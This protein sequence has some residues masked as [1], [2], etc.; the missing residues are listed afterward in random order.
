MKSFYSHCSLISLLVFAMLSG[1][2]LDQLKAQTAYGMSLEEKSGYSESHAVVTADGKQLF[3]ARS[4]H[5]QN[6][7][8][9]D[10]SDIWYATMQEDG[11]WSAAINLGRPLN[12]H[13][14][15]YPV[16]LTNQGQ[17]LFVL[18]EGNDGNKKV[19]RSELHGRIWGNPVP[20]A[21]HHLDSIGLLIDF[22][23]SI[24]GV[25][26]IASI[27]D[28][29]GQV[30]LYYTYALTDNEWA[31]PTSLGS[32]VN[33]VFREL[34]PYLAA[35]GES[36]FFCRESDG[37]KAWFY[38]RKMPSDSVVQWQEPVELKTFLP[39]I[40]EASFINTSLDGRYAKL[41][42]I[43][44]RQ[45][46][47][48]FLTLDL[49]AAIRPSPV[50]VLSGSVYDADTGMPIE[51]MLDLAIVDDGQ[52][53]QRS[54]FGN[55][56]IVSKKEQVAQIVPRTEGYLPLS[57][58]LQRVDNIEKEEIDIDFP[59]LRGQAVSVNDSLLLDIA[60]CSRVVK[61]FGEERK[62]YPDLAVLKSKCSIDYLLKD[63]GSKRLAMS[64]N[65]AFQ[66]LLDGYKNRFYELIAASDLESG[67]ESYLDS[68]N[69]WVNV[70]DRWQLNL[71]AKSDSTRNIFQ[72]SVRE[73]DISTEWH[74]NTTK[75]EPF[76]QFEYWVRIN[77]L[78]EHISKLGI[79]LND[80]VSAALNE[81]LVWMF[82][83]D[84]DKLVK[85]KDWE[86]IAED[87]SQKLTLML[88]A[89]VDKIAAQLHEPDFPAGKKEALKQ[90]G[91]ELANF[92]TSALLEE[93]ASYFF[94]LSKWIKME[95]IVQDVENRVNQLLIG[96]LESYIRRDMGKDSLLEKDI[97]QGESEV[98]IV[99]AASENEPVD[100]LYLLDLAL[101]QV[102]P[103]MQI[104]L[105]GVDFDKGTA[106]LKPHSINSL[107]RLICLLNDYP[108]LV[109]EVSG[110]G[111]GQCNALYAKTLSELRAERVV[112][113]IKAGGIDS[114]RLR[115]KGYGAEQPV[116]I[117]VGEK[118][119]LKNQRIEVK[120]IEMTSEGRRKNAIGQGVNG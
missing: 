118:N 24:S 113:I 55:Y 19:F 42:K 8:I 35:D 108:G 83:E 115:H 32:E 111:N 23:V 119:Q 5:P 38:S 68:E 87:A 105:E 50:I 25:E 51:T 13:E 75:V 117:G 56:Q 40:G 69:E 109:I 33:S 49:P 43:E 45:L 82:N 99:E 20:L 101:T 96:H 94:E 74:T 78:K 67:V 39:E 86:Q 21:I 16:G 31:R 62:G 63:E 4:S 14:K 120:I 11:S 65:K 107:R 64:K 102:E 44:E 61:K 98:F 15:N 103:G 97:R 22:F 6:I 114:R 7:G 85:W 112:E 30:D 106:V 47:S 77:I 59:A 37:N 66:S 100:R 80:R 26:A 95:S 10:K 12:N 28:P 17:T 2:F 89:E 3:F 53:I 90:L 76:E 104:V 81:E 116:S 52:S 29:E 34:N 58:Y 71:M 9:D 27:Q 54:Y 48:F 79:M 84:T 73:K 46:P 72:D 70:L 88:A 1:G 36:L 110:H 92:E 18:T 91:Q 57:L 60:L 93:V 41:V